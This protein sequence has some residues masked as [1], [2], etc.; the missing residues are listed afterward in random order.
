MVALPENLKQKYYV[1][2]I[3]KDHI[4]HHISFHNDN[5]RI[6]E[7]QVIYQMMCETKQL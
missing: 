1:G 4:S 6:T 3:S 5:R 7:I 2:D